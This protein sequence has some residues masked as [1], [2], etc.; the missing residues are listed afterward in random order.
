MTRDVFAWVLNQYFGIMDIFIMP[1][2]TVCQVPKGLVDMDFFCLGGV[3]AQE[4]L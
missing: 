1:L 4:E 3:Q 2:R